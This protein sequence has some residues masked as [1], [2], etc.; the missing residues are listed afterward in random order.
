PEPESA[1]ESE[2]DEEPEPE[3]EAPETDSEYDIHEAAERIEEQVMDM[4]FPVPATSSR[5]FVTSSLEVP[6]EDADEVLA[7]AIRLA[8]SWGTITVTIKEDADGG[9]MEEARW[10]NVI[11]EK[12]GD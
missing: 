10:Q 6:D 8:E 5:R 9:T 4:E 3:R 1:E 7:Q 12:A 2:A 11:I